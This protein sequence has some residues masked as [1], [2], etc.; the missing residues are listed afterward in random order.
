MI[1]DNR[2]WIFV[3]NHSFETWELGRMGQLTCVSIN[4]KRPTFIFVGAS[5]EWITGEEKLN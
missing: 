4:G 5:L 1:K 2:E 3:F